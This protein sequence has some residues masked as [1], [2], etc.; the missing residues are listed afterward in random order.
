MKELHIYQVSALASFSKVYRKDDRGRGKPRPVY[1]VWPR[2]KGQVLRP[3]IFGKR[4]GLNKN[5]LAAQME[6]EDHL[7]LSA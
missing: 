4:L 2:V 1:I 5:S 7:L 3:N 6:L